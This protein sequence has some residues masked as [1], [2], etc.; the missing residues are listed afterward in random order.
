MNQVKQWSA[1]KVTK[2]VYDIIA[3]RAKQEERA[4]SVVLRRAVRAYIGKEE[5]RHGK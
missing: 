3:N 2:D 5:V 4:I 1:I